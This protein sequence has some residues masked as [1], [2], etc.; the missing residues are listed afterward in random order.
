MFSKETVAPGLNESAS[1]RYFNLAVY[2]TCCL[3]LPL[4]VT[5]LHLHAHLCSCRRA[6]VFA[7]PTKCACV[8]ACSCVREGALMCVLQELRNMV[9]T[10]AVDGLGVSGAL[11]CATHNMWCTL[12]VVY[13][14]C[15][16]H[17]KICTS[18][19]PADNTMN[20]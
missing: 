11:M 13:T 4:H 1:L 17:C 9:R 19:E 3:H 16:V 12:H 2:T 15:G 6:L 10:A 8:C 14:A 5:W 18:A 20:E 7:L